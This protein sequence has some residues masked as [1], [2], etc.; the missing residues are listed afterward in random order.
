M[1]VSAVRECTA[2]LAVQLQRLT[3]CIEERELPQWQYIWQYGYR[4]RDKSLQPQND[5]ESC[6]IQPPVGSWSFAQCG[7]YRSGHLRITRELCDTTHA[8]N[9]GASGGGLCHSLLSLERRLERSK[10]G[11]VLSSMG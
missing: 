6:A 11:A 5:C 8:L 3:E 1:K 9:L 4:V 2:A 10:F 7:L